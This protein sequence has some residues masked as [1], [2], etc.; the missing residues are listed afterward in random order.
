[1]TPLQR[2][3]KEKIEEAR[4]T[5]MN[6]NDP[7]YPFQI[8]FGDM[9]TCYNATEVAYLLKKFPPCKMYKHFDSCTAYYPVNKAQKK[10]TVI[11]V[12]P[13]HM[14]CKGLTSYTY[15]LRWYTVI[16]GNFFTVRVIINYGPEL[17]GIT[18]KY[19]DSRQLPK[20]SQ[21]K[22]TPKVRGLKA[23]MYYGDSGDYMTKFLCE[24]EDI[25]NKEFFIL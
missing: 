3:V 11:E 7:Y 15:I 8:I 13:V 22:A 5:K 25:N 4:K 20:Y 12:N 18:F 6:T 16:E 1:M 10:E 14:W 23:H 17:V 24:V 9:Y 2:K 19:N 21:F